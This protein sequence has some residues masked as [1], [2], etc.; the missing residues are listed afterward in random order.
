[1]NLKTEILVG[2]IRCWKGCGTY[3]DPSSTF[4]IIV[5]EYKITNIHT[6][7]LFVSYTVLELATLEQFELAEK[8]II[9]ESDIVEA[10][11]GHG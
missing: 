9:Y 1:M 2:D 6:N 10:N 5:E 7:E 4:F 11:D 8:T 3:Y